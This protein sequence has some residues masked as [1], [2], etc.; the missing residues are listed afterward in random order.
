MSHSS[1]THLVEEGKK[2]FLFFY[3]SLLLV[4]V[5]GV[6]V[7]IIYMKTFEPSSL[8]IVLAVASVIKFI[9]VI[10]WFMHLKWDKA[11]LTI[12]FISGLV[13]AVCTFTALQY[14]MVDHVKHID[15]VLEGDAPAASAA[16]KATTHH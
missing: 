13:V 9:A 3:V 14:I 4:A 6:E 1:D 16:N 7:V 12:V 8:F 11:F 15:K 10:W 5:T 2:Y